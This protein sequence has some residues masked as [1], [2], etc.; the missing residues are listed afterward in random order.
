MRHQ[1][2]FGKHRVLVGAAVLVGVFQDHDAI[3][4]SV[5]RLDVGVSRA[6]GNPGPPACIPVEVD[7]IGDHRIL[8]E[9]IDF[10][11][12]R[13]GEILQFGVGIRPGNVLGHLVVRVIARRFPGI[14]PLDGIAV[15]PG[16]PEPG[17]QFLLF[18]RQLLEVVQFI[19]QV[20]HFVAAEKKDVRLVERAEPPAVEFVLLDDQLAQFLGLVE[21]RAGRDGNALAP[22]LGPVLKADFPV[23]LQCRI[24]RGGNAPWSSPG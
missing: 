10:E 1:Q 23:D 3:I 14:E 8:G 2:T 13:D 17:D 6:G 12:I 21:I 11:T 4:R 9:K 19:G 15:W 20:P 24:A 16:Y 7:R 5:T 22:L 18:F